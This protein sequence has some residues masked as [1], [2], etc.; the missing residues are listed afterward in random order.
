MVVVVSLWTWWHVL[1]I[2]GC[3]IP[4]GPS[5]RGPISLHDIGFI[6]LK[7]PPH[8]AHFL[9]DLPS[10]YRC[11]IH[12]RSDLVH[13]GSLVAHLHLLLLL[14]LLLLIPAKVHVIEGF[15]IEDFII[16][17]GHSLLITT[18][19]RMILL[20]EVGHGL[21]VVES[22]CHPIVTCILLEGLLVL[23]LSQH[24]LHHL[25]LRLFG[26]T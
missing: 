22:V 18:R 26:T 17:A 12:L 7:G 10:C 4:T 20:R 21:P 8:Q 3:A 6:I 1:D 23:A 9:L 2:W 15:W 25:L 11:R 24:A 13:L 14:V 19:S 5:I 16:V